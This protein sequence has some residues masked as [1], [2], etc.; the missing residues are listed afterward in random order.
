MCDF[1]N[2]QFDFFIEC[3]KFNRVIIQGGAFHRNAG[4]VLQAM[5]T[6][7]ES[8]EETGHGG[9]ALAFQE[10]DARVPHEQYTLGYAGQCYV[11]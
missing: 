6:L 2:N 9:N 3:D 8:S 11:V 1:N 7:K 10:Y 5:V 4:H